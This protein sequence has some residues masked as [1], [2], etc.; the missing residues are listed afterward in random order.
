MRASESSATAARVPEPGDNA[1]IA[2]E[3]L[4]AGTRLRHDGGEIT[5]AHTVLEGHRFAITAIPEGAELRRGGS[6][7]GRALRDIA[8][9]EYACNGKILD[10]LRARHSVRLPGDDEP[11]A[12][13]TRAAAV[14]RAARTAAHSTFPMRRTSRTPSLPRSRST[15]PPSGPRARHRWSRGHARFLGYRR[16]GGRGVGTR[17]HI[18][19]LGITSRTART[20][21]RS[22]AA[23][24]GSPTS[25]RTSTASWPCPHRGRRAA[26][27]EQPRPAAAHA[28]RVR[29]ASQR[30]RRP[31]R[32]RARR[33]R[34]RRAAARLRRRARRAA[35]ARPA[36]LPSLG[37]G[38]RRD[39]DA[40]EAIV[41]GWI[42]PVAAAR[43]TEEPLTE[44]R[45]ALQ[46]GGSD[47]FS[48]ISPT[49][50]RARSAHERSATVARPCWPRP[51]S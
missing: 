8:A 30:R 32:R 46:C 22:R 2:V 51:T 27:A 43:R 20:R 5:L 17:N 23:C 26:R 45:I 42:G 9:G 28:H 16:A 33:H 49:R 37:G 6:P 10:V 47:A 3:R 25:T 44:L 12:R 4:E 7:F 1:A 24:A 48:G 21:R 29:R 39:L 11:R 13:T 15:S 38:F 41:R 31:D 19:V 34:Q 40:G 50:S 14:C 35:R 36:R 18:V